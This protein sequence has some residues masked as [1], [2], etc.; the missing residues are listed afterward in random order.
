MKCLITT[1]LTP[2]SQGEEIVSLEPYLKKLKIEGENQSKMM[3]KVHQPK[4]S[5]YSDGKSVIDIELRRLELAVGL[6]LV[7]EARKQEL[8]QELEKQD[9]ID[10]LNR[11]GLCSKSEATV[12]IKEM[13][14]S[15]ERD[16][17]WNE[18]LT[19]SQTKII[20]G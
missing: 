19:R 18:R 1:V 17:I 11:L 9:K 13:E 10:F 15:T 4:N 2:Q 6:K 14:K 7:E 8:N 20:F 16:N 12:R 3:E 5:E